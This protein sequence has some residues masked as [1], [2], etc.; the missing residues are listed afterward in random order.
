MLPTTVVEATTMKKFTIQGITDEVDTCECCGRK[1]L[2]RTVALA[3][4][5][6]LVTFFGTECAAQALKLPAADVRKGAKAAQDAADELVRKERARQTEAENLR[7][8]GFLRARSGLVGADVGVMIQALGGFA[9]ARDAF[10]NQ[11]DG[12]TP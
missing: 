4:E 11:R 3:D 6:G 1:N 12:V 8:V 7:W 2:K 9:A 10:R 5:H